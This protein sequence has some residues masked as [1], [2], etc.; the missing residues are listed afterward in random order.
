MKKKREND[1]ITLSIKVEKTQL[2]MVSVLC[3]KKCV[4]LS[5]LLSI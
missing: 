1:K 2:P 5:F 3:L 4:Q